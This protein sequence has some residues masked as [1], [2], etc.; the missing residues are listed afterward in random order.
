MGTH[1]H[2][3]VE[4]EEYVRAAEAAGMDEKE[5]ASVIELLATDP[6]A[7][8][9][10]GGSLYKVRIARKGS[11]KSGGYRVVYFYRD[12]NLPVFLLT[13]FAKNQQADISPKAKAIFIAVCKQIAENYGVDE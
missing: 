7:G 4:L 10:L 3:V 13:A 9:S 11:G 5:Q 6:E 8:V 2:T 1:Y 12:E